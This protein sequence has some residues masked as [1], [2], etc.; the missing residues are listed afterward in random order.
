[1]L[2]SEEMSLTVSRI[3][4][5]RYLARIWRGQVEHARIWYGRVERGLDVDVR[6]DGVDHRSGHHISGTQVISVCSARG[7][8]RHWSQAVRLTLERDQPYY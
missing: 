5:R 4:R 3:L 1:M 7:N 8:R 6:G 2:R